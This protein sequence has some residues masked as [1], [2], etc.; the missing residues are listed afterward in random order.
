MAFKPRSIP[1]TGA[2]ARGN[3]GLFLES[4]AFLRR[5]NPAYREVA[6]TF[7]DG[8][9]PESLRVI[10]EHLQTYGV[11]ATFFVVGKRV[12]EHPEWARRVVDAGHEIGNHTFTHHRLTSLSPEQAAWQVDACEQ[13][14]VEATGV[15]P[16]FFRPPGMR[17]SEALL[18]RLKAKGYV[19]IGWSD[20]AKDFETESY[21]IADLTP[22]DIAERVLARVQNGG[23]V[24][25]HDTDQTAAALPRVISYL[26]VNGFRFVTVS[27]MLARLPKPVALQA[28]IQTMRSR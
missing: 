3:E 17:H 25:L 28:Q 20:A 19:T 24:L 27:E 4:K 15:L 18:Q 22:D 13:A 7:D 11:R 2:R 10:L 16:R 1:S 14:I 6:L 9:H 12:E 5:G 8:P 21:K 26:R 23:I